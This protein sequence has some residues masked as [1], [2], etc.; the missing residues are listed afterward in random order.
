MRCSCASLTHGA[1]CSTSHTSNGSNLEHA[2][3]SPL[4]LTDRSFDAAAEFLL[5]ISA[6]SVAPLATFG[7][8]YTARE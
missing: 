7:K 3:N 4:L 5:M 6:Q 2:P 1:G 8:R